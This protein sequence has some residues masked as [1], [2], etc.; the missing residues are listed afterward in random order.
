LPDTSSMKVVAKI[1]ETQVT[2]LRVDPNIP[3]RA[4]IKVPGQPQ[5]FTGWLS[6][7]SVLADSSQRWWNPDSKEYPV[8]VTLDQTPGGLKPGMG[9]EVRVFID[10]LRNVLAVPLAAV[11]AAGRDSYVFV[12]EGGD[13]RPVQVNIGEVNETHAQLTRGIASGQ[14]VLIL[15][16][17]QGREL[18]DK[19]G[20]KIQQSDNSEDVFKKLNKD[21]KKPSATPNGAPKSDAPAAGQPSDQP[22][23]TQRSRNGGSPTSA[24]TTMPAPPPITSAR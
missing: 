3:M 18:L 21:S 13:V 11:Y 16:A 7:I 4:T 2:R 19:A 1:N 6:N 23:R 8:D 5:A 22:G 20:I 17:G 14:Q 15:A 10:R 24:P 9:A 12:K